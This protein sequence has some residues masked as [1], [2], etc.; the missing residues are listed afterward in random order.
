[1]SVV[2]SSILYL[3]ADNLNF[4]NPSGNKWKSKEIIRCNMY[5]LLSPA[6]RLSTDSGTGAL[7]SYFKSNRLCMVGC[8]CL[9]QYLPPPETRVLFSCQIPMLI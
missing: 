6:E 2:S 7:I 4:S 5:F 9:Y 3:I 1:M 8:F